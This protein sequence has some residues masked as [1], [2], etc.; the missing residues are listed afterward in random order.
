MIKIR[1]EGTAEELPKAVQQIRESF[2]VLNE[3]N[4]YKNY[5]NS[6]YHRMYIDAEIPKT[7]N[8]QT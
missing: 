4:S 3:S 2:R 5:G 7:V 6:V 8:T 1:L